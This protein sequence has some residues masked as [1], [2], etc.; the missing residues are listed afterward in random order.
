[1]RVLLVEDEV[2]LADNLSAA[3]R[4]GPGFAVDWAADGEA[5][6]D[7]CAQSLLRPR[8]PRPDAAQAR[9]PSAFCAACAPAKIAT[10]VLILTAKEGKDTIVQLLNAGADDYLAK[11]FDLGELLAR[12][13]ALIRRGKGAAHPTLNALG[14]TSTPWS[15]PSTAAASSS[16]SRPPNTTSS[17]TCCTIRA[18]SSASRNCSN[19]STTTTG[20]TT[21]TSSRRTSP[22]CARSSMP[23]YP[24]PTP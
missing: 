16:I 2:R 18:R 12:A 8:H 10:P 24:M 14:V 7:C 17:N 19:T 15:R 3:L 1:M 21:P 6:D 5:G 11:P 13:K 23:P 20:S 22:T 9:R 4:D